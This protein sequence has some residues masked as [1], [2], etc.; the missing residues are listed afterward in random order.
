MSKETQRR[1]N[2]WLVP[3]YV[4]AAP[5]YVLRFVLSLRRAWGLWRISRLGYV[6]CQHCGEENAIDIL[7]TC[8]RCKTVEYGNRLRCTGCGLRATGFPCDTCSVT[9]RCC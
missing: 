5:V 2:G 4:V 8:P 3:L 9:I 1:P 6:D 7:A